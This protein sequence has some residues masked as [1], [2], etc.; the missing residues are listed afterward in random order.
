MQRNDPYS[1]LIL[2]VA[3]SHDRE[4]FAALFHHFAP[5]IKAYLMRLG[6]DNP[7][8]EELTQEVMTLLWR[9]AGLFDP[10]K[11]SSSTWL[12]RIARNRRIDFLRRQK[13]PDI[14]PDDPVLMPS[15]PPGG[16]EIIDAGIRE[17]RVQAA[18][19]S[20]P[21]EQ[22]ELIRL[23]FF[24]GYSHSQIS[25]ETGIP[26]G[27]VKSRIRLAFT[28]LRTVLAADAAIDID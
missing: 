22:F 5:R 12:F 20:L 27:T 4:A 23:A 19:K 9:K 21:G 11:S 18:L 1:S 28:K 16:D 13:V 26:L 3:A 17:R 8:A 14:E 6:S 7:S 25:E 15:E 10:A 24:Q 2:R